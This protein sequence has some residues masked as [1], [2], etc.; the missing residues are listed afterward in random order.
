MVVLGRLRGLVGL[1]AA[2]VERW[3]TGGAGTEFV[4]AGTHNVR[5]T[6]SIVKA[7]QCTMAS[8]FSRLSPRKDESVNR[9]DW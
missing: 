9:L 7:S 4:A 6:A 2:V 3:V 1:L 5:R 8:G